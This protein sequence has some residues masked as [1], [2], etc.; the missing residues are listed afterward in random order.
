MNVNDEN[1]LALL[2]NQV[3]YF[4]RVFA[5]EARVIE[6]Q[7]FDVKALSKGRR[8]IL[9]ESVEALRHLALDE[10]TMRYSRISTYHELEILRKARDEA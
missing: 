9:E 3:E 10:P 7:C 6:A 4:R 5:Y 1:E 2:R 8:R